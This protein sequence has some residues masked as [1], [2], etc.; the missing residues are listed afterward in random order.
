MPSVTLDWVQNLPFKMQSVLFSGLRGPD[1]GDL[2]GI[3]AIVRWLR[4]VTQ[5]NADQSSDYMRKHP[6][7]GWEDVRKELECEC[8][9][10]YYGHL[11]HTFQ[12]IG[13]KHPD[14]LTKAQALGF[15]HKMVDML[16]LLPEGEV[17]MDRRLQD[18]EE[19]RE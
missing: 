9:V 3:K 10:H 19:S 12:I 5:H 18:R 1:T 13:Y 14:P 15:Y 17:R 6:L 11:L 7:P 2:R 16:H 4:P 8:S